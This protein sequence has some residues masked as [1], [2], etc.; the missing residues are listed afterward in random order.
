[1]LPPFTF[2]RTELSE[3]SARLA[4]SKKIVLSCV[5]IIVGISCAETHGVEAAIPPLSIVV[6]KLKDALGS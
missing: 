3:G 2:E 5:G 6:F 4:G 1:M